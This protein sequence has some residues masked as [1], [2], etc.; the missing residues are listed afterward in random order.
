MHKIILSDDI[1]INSEKTHLIYNCNYLDVSNI[2]LLLNYD[3]ITIKYP[4]SKEK[5]PYSTR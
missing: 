5:L 1:E 3:K 4:K 2:T